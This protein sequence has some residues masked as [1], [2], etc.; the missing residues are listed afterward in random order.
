VSINQQNLRGVKR[1]AIFRALFLGD[2]LCI[3]PTVRA[4]R[5]AYPEAEITLIGLPWQTEF[6]KRFSMYFDHFI[7]FPG[8]PSLPEQ[9]PDT[10]RILSFLKLVRSKK[11]DLVFQMQGNG[12][13]TNDMCRLWNARIVT[14]LRTRN[15]PVR[16]EW[17]F[18]ESDDNDHE[19]LKFFKLLDPQKIPHHG[20][21]LEF[22]FRESEMEAF[23]SIR[24]RLGVGDDPYICIHP[25]ARDSRRRWGLENFAFISRHLFARGLK[26]VLT[27]SLQ[28]SKLLQSLQGL[29][30]YPVTNIIEQMGDVDLGTLASIIKGS[31]MLISNDT[32]VSHIASALR[33]PSVIIFSPY[34]VMRRW[35]PLNTT[36]HKS[37]DHERAND[38]ESVLYTVL[39]HLQNQPERSPVFLNNI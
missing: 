29:I 32:G 5:R 6:V 13:V 3:I 20:T 11:F 26:I 34:S 37:V 27:G 22:P 36:L 39:D 14:G 15:D 7:D 30:E 28:E 31:R 2:M 8:W 9:E 25:G 12:K 35:A 4:I 38:P 16:E 17:L 23:A 24:G 10:Q 1:I 21:D 19:V 18:P 33:T